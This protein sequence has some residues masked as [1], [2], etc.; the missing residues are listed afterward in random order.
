[1]LCEKEMHTNG[2]EGYYFVY[3][4]FRKIN[5]SYLTDAQRIKLDTPHV[6]QITTIQVKEKNDNLK[7]GSPV[8]VSRMLA[9]LGRKLHVMETVSFVPYHTSC[10]ELRTAMPCFS[11][12]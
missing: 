5:F 9:T 8:H 2:L 7:A 1:M 6:R 10:M 11:S 4:F 12:S 3:P